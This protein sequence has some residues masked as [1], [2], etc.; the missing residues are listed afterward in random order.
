MVRS[1]GKLVAASLR[2]AVGAVP[3]VEA[4]ARGEAAP[5]RPPSADQVYV[6]LVHGYGAAQVYERFLSMSPEFLH[7]ERARTP[8][9]DTLVGAGHFYSEGLTGRTIDQLID[10]V[11]DVLD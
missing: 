9:D 7:A 5:P 8:H 1:M 2:P 10:L 6:L 3:E 11:L 4:G